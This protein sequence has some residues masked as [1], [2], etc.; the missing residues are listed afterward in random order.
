V[1]P[2]QAPPAANRTQPVGKRHAPDKPAG[3]AGRAMQ[4]LAPQQALNIAGIR[5]SRLMYRPKHS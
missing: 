1:G 4:V 2:V 3:L 5:T